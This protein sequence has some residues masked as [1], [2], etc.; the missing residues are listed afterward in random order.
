MKRVG[1]RQRAVFVNVV[2]LSLLLFSW[3]SCLVGDIAMA[4]LPFR[5]RAIM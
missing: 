2:S 3:S 1:R 4:L 5:C